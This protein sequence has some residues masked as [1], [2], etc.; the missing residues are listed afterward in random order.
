MTPDDALKCLLKGNERYIESDLFYPR[1]GV[2]RCLETAE[3]QKPFG[4]VTTCA[5]SRMSPEIIYKTI[6]SKSESCHKSY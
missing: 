4:A 5:D 6:D 1:Q 3:I 2:Y